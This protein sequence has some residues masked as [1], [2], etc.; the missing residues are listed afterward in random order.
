MHPI[1]A[2]MKLSNWS[3]EYVQMR[4]NVKKISYRKWGG[5]GACVNKLSFEGAHKHSSIV[6][7]HFCA[8]G[9]SIS[10]EVVITVKFKSI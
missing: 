4:K 6:Q 7:Y 5:G 1:E 3:S 9:S 2:F 8:H 10:L